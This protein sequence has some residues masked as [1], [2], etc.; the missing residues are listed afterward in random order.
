MQRFNLGLKLIYIGFHEVEK[1]NF[2]IVRLFFNRI[3]HEDGYSEEECLQY[4]AVVYSNTLQSLITIVRAMG[5]LK[6]DFESSERAVSKPSL[7]V[8]L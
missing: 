8:F 5:H 2:I 7:H 1:A 6:I 4:K 3:I